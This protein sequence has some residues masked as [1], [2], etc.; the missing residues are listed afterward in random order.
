MSGM[1]PLDWGILSDK[2]VSSVESRTVLTPNL[3][4][5]VFILIILPIPCRFDV[6]RLISH[7]NLNVFIQNLSKL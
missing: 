5:S 2:R 3:R 1:R 7:F 6:S 4:F